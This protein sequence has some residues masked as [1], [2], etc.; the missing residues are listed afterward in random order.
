MALSAR[1]REASAPKNGTPCSIGKVYDF[2]AE[3]KPGELAELNAILYE[4][5]NDQSEVYSLL[6]ELGE[7]PFKP[8]FQT[9]NKHRGKKCR[10]FRH[11][12]FRFCHECKRDIPSCVCG[13]R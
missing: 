6:T 9:I 5:G 12:P 4:E 13:T 3:T 10:C 2:Y 7:L 1:T 11:E 8:G